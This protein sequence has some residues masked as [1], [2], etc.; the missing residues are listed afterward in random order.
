MEGNI[1]PNPELSESVNDMQD[2]YSGTVP[3]VSKT[4]KLMLWHASS[5]PLPCPVH[6]LLAGRY[7]RPAATGKLNVYSTFYDVVEARSVR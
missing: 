4:L 2:G 3:V 7:R 6:V 5:D 1:E